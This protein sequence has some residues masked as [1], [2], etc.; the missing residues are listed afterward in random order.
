MEA[1]GEDRAGDWPI[2]DVA[3]MAGTT[4]RTLRH[5]DDIGL[6]K[7]TRVGSNG[8]RYYN[9]G[10]LLQLQRILLLRE[11]GLGLPA[12]A[13]VFRH[14]ADPVRAL[15][16]HLEWL[17]QE[18]ERL[19][20]QVRSVRQT[21]ETMQQ[22]G[23]LVAEKMFDGFDH[24]QYKDEVEERWG[25]DAY[26]KSDAWWRGMDAAEKREWKSRSEGLGRDWQAA[27]GSGVAP[28]SDEAQDLAARH[29]AWLRS[30]PGTPAAE[31]GG[32]IKGYVAGLAD[33][34]VADPR[35]AANYGG[36]AGA[37]FVRDALRTYADRNL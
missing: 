4:S 18:Q 1:T 14:Q 19:A 25:K 36:E 28:G 10:A 31:A 33:M 20:R 27:A 12:I 34:Y 26:A 23:N 29:V 3:R 9:G 21:I 16:R 17:D 37:T 24:T 22:G 35:F 8:Y 7:P 5:Y 13:E 2:Q 32:D 30:I 6:L 11:L 15:T